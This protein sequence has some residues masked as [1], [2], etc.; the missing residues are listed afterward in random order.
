ME[1]TAAF[2]CRVA[3]L[4]HLFYVIQYHIVDL[5]DVIISFRALCVEN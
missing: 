5:A 2:K 4:N 3:F 1:G